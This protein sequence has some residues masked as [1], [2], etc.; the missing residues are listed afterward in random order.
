MGKKYKYA[1]VQ[2]IKGEF[3]GEEDGS[4]NPYIRVTVKVLASQDMPHRVG[5]EC[6]EVLSLSDKAA[7]YTAENLRRLGWSCNDITELE[8]LGATVVTGGFYQDSYEGKTREKIAF[9]DK[10]AQKAAVT[11]KAKKGWASKFKKLAATV[12][13]VEV[14]EANKG[15]ER[16]EMPE[17][18]HTAAPPPQDDPFGDDSLE[19]D[20]F[21]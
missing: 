14:T 21:S 17:V 13:K 15:W 7:P 4:G 3:I 8:G 20:F 10:K 16:N 11:G 2:A 5:E 12:E 9:F 19:D 1:D 18:D 6:T